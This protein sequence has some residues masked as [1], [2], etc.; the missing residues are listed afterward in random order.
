[1]SGK[2]ATTVLIIEKDEKTAELFFRNFVEKNT[3]L[4]CRKIVAATPE[5]GLVEWGKVPRPDI[6]IFGAAVYHSLSFHDGLKLLRYRVQKSDQ[7][8][9]S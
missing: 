3:Q 5:A 1:M 4:A 6:I 2:K 9:C 7:G 8:G